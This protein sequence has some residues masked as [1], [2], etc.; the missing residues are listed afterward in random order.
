MSIVLKNKKVTLE[1]H[2][3]HEGYNGARFTHIGKL[4]AMKF[5]GISC[6]T[7]EL[8]SGFSKKSG[9]GFYNEFDI[10]TALGFNEVHED[11]WFHKIGVGLLKK[12]NSNYDF[13]KDYE[14]I[15]AETSIEVSEEAV[16]FRCIQKEHNGYG[17]E[18]I[19]SYVLKED[20]FEIQYTLQN[21][22]SKMIKTV[23]YNHN[24]L[25]VA[26]GVIGSQCNLK[27]AKDVTTSKQSEVVNPEEVF[28][29]S[30][31]KMTFNGIPKSDF[32]VSDL[33][34]ESGAS[35]MWEYLQNN[36]KI[37]ATTDIK[38]LKMNIWG[39][40]H[41]IS[42]ELFVEIQVQPGAQKSWKRAYT[43]EQY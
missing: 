20:G 14:V 3:P 29:F 2:Q 27:Y 43:F 12:T 22:G 35:L 25:S 17:Y 18:L 21:K 28:T 4:F 33:Q 42:P 23:E 11:Q 15:P 6:V 30:L 1:F 37:Q 36:M 7:S 32:F 9:A 34:A 41:V 39:A 31:G 13:F 40:G 26:N 8:N 5:N 38:P 16:L 24:F 19:Q 10:D